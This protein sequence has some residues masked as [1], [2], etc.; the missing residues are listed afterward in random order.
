MR[1]HC[2]TGFTAVSIQ[3]HKG[4]IGDVYN[5]LKSGMDDILQPSE[6]SQGII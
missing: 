1:K 5:T 4:H 2:Y 3:Q 6:Y